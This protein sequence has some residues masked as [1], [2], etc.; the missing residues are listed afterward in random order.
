MAQAAYFVNDLKIVDKGR[1]L[2]IEAQRQ[3]EHGHIVDQILLACPAQLRHVFADFAAGLAA[4]AQPA[5]TAADSVG[6]RP[7]PNRLGG[8]FW[9]DN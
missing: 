7:R 2:I 6:G 5:K 1:F 4:D 9:Q 8:Y 3:C